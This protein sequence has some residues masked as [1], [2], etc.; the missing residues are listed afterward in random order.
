MYSVFDSVTV[1]KTFVKNIFSTVYIFTKNDPKKI[2]NYIE[3]TINRGV[4]YWEAVGGYKENKT[5]IV[6]SAL[7]KYESFLLQQ[8]IKDIDPYAFVVS[9]DGVN[10]ILSI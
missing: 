10:I 3:N 5:F 8:N 2:V 7:S 4:T 1:D 9:N 6:Y